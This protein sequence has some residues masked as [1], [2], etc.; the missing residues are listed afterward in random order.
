MDAIEGK[1][2]EIKVEERE[3]VNVIEPV[4]LVGAP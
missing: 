3:V 2:Y 1:V 4:G